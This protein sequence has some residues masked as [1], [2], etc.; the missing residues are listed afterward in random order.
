[1]CLVEEKHARRMGFAQGI[2]SRCV[3]PKKEEGKLRSGPQGADTGD[4]LPRKGVWGR[5]AESERISP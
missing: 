4:L 3:L 1:M 5:G 2:V